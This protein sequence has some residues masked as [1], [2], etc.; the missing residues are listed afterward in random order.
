M[1]RL[2]SL[3]FEND[4]QAPGEL[5]KAIAIVKGLQA[6]GFSYKGAVA[7]TGNIAHESGCEPNQTEINGT[8][9]YGLCQWD[10]G[11]GRLKALQEFAK[12]TNQPVGSLKTQLDFMQCELIN[13]YVWN[14]KPIPNIN[15]KL[16]YT[17]DKAGKILG[18]ANYY[19]KKYNNCLAKGD[20]T[21]V[22]TEMESKIF[23]PQP[24]STKKRVDNAKKIHDAISSGEKNPAAAD[25]KKPDTVT[26]NVVKYKASPNPT[27]PGG[28]VT[29][30]VSKDILPLASVDLNILTS[31]GKSV[32]THH[33]D[34]VSQGIL[35]FTAPSAAG[36]YFLKFST[37][38]AATTHTIKILVQ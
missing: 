2:K 4:L 24:G 25:T 16:I 22:T 5:D 32:D 10:P 1:I 31:T 3:L 17:V 14:G 36:T 13:G 30:T 27:T 34:S 26:S 9:A 18:L 28:S 7:L 33:W 29:V 20:L 21:A 37:G 35:K 6:R 15:K 12:M 23:S 38:D 8:G 19:V 11:A